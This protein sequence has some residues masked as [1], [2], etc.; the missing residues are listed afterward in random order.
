MT[1]VRN[2][3][4]IIVPVATPMNAD[5]SVDQAGLKAQV[6]HVLDGGVVGIFVMGTTGEFPMLSDAERVT[7]I[8][9]VMA[10][11]NGRV[12]VLVGVAAPGTARALAYC[13]QGE[14]LGADA[15]VAAAP[16]YYKL[17][18]AVEGYEYFAEIARSTSLPVFLYNI[19]SYTQMPLDMETIQRLAEL[20]NV[21][22]MKDSSSDF[23]FFCRLAHKLNRGKD[24]RLYQGNEC[25][26]LAS[27]LRGAS[28]GVN[29]L[30]NVAPKMICDLYQAHRAGDPSKARELQEKVISLFDIARLGPNAIPAFKVALSELGICGDYAS[31]PFERLGDEKRAIV[32]NK[33]VELGLL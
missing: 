16:Y 1:D 20:P 14:A 26:L 24:L 29:G 13:R 19:P 22:G 23:T 4:G 7:V 18:G 6:N 31:S 12:S 25:H 5:R 21:V 30:A 33:L 28:G 11:V 10:A 27:L 8:E 32:K 15:L 17:R 3:E 2:L 9:T